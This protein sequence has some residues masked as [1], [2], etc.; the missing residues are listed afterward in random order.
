MRYGDRLAIGDRILTLTN[1]HRLGLIN[2]ERGLVTGVDH[3]THDIEVLFDARRERT[4]IPAAYIEAGGL[5]YGYAMT[6]HKAQGLTCDRAY[7]L[8]DEHLHREAAYTALSRDR[9]QN[10]LYA[11]EPDPDH[12]THTA[13]DSDLV[14]DAIRRA[15]E[16]RERK[17]LASEW[18][19]RGRSAERAQ[20][21]GMEL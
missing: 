11:V 20:D 17:S 1:D 9:H 3:V 16:Q 21:V 19:P 4:T 8:G 5:D 15:F 10:R 7:T 2:G 14:R 13:T 6:I 12:E 18:L